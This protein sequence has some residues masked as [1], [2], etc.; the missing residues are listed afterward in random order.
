MHGIGIF[1][2]FTAVFR[3][4][5]LF[6]LISSVPKERAWWMLTWA[7]I[8]LR[9]GQEEPQNEESWKKP[10]ITWGFERKSRKG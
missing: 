7:R 9:G 8:E 2:S 10:H 6:S 5:H 1:G 3:V 4:A